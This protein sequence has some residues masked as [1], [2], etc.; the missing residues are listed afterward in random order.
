MLSKTWLLVG[1]THPLNDLLAFSKPTISNFSSL[2]ASNAHLPSFLLAIC[3]CLDSYSL[4]NSLMHFH[5]FSSLIEPAVEAYDQMTPPYN[6]K[7]S[8]S[9]S[10]SYN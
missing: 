1:L 10:L 5:F 7:F 8:S 9:H 3:S 2:V 6:P 4:E